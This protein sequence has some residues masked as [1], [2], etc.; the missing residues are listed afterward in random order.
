MKLDKVII[1]LGIAVFFIGLSAYLPQ[2]DLHW[3]DFSSLGTADIQ[4]FQISIIL[5]AI[6]FLSSVFV[7]GVV[8]E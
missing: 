5:I 2:I 1:N 4:I 8:N 7:W 6:G 3:I